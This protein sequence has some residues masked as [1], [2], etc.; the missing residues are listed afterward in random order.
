MAEDLA[1]GRP[2]ELDAFSGHVIALGAEHRLPTPVTR[3]VHGILTA[4]E[5]SPR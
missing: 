5:N 1:S 3:T 2:L 4:L